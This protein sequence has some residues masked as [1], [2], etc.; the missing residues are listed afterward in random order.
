MPRDGS[1]TRTAI[2]DAAE[3]LTLERGFAGAPVDRII[4]DAGVTKGAFFH[5]F[6]SKQ[7]LADALIRRWALGDARHLEGKLTRAE[8]LVDD[9]LRQLDLF[10]GFFVEEAEE[11]AGEL[12]GCLFAAY[13]YQAGLFEDDTLEVLAEAMRLWRHRLRAKLEEVALTRPPARGIDLDALADSI[14]VVF[15]GSYVVSR[16]LRQP[17]VVVAQLRLF[18]TQLALSFAE[19]G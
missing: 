5:H 3:A 10:V 18:R 6:A 19:F 17:E 12:P 9:P 13:T 7:D 15:E 4:G 16:A 2:L 8:R 1:T 11:S 14:T